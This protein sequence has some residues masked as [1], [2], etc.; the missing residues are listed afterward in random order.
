[1]S[2]GARR[3]RVYVGGISRDPSV[4]LGLSASWSLEDLL[5][6]YV[7]PARMIRDGRV[8][9]VGPL[10]ASPGRVCV[11]GVGVLEY[12]PTDGL[13]TLLESYP[14]MEELVEYTL[15][16]PG[17]H[18]TVRRLAELGLLGERPVNAGGCS[19][20]PRL[21]LARLLKHVLP[22]GEDIVILMVAG[23]GSGGGILYRMVSTPMGSYTGMSRATS[24]FHV[25]AAIAVSEG[26]VGPGLVYPERIGESGEAWSIVERVLDHM[27]LRVEEERCGGLEEC[28]KP[29]GAGTAG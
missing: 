11:R 22:E 6:E 24:S 28:V 8:I 10:D 26:V 16:W 29:A 21:F 19:V 3:A 7:R 27:K 4:P 9:S 23:E 1:M 5:D 12:F 20:V 14:D 25:A 15:R 2:V 17:H 13:R 18:D